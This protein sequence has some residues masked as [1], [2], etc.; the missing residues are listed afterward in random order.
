MHT[1]MNHNRMPRLLDLFCS[2]GGSCKGYQDAGFYVVGVD[3][4]YQPRYPGDY[5]IQ[6]DVMTWLPIAIETG[7]IDGFD[8]IHSSPPCQAHSIL[9]NMPNVDPESHDD[10]IEPVRNLL[11]ETGK[12]YVIENVPGAPLESPIRLCGSSFGL[13][14]QKHRLFELS[15]FVLAPPCQHHWQDSDPIYTVR[16]HGAHR[17]TGICYVFGNG[18][19]KGD[20]W[21]GAMGI[22]WMTRDE[23]SQAIPPAYTRWLG[24][25][26]LRAIQ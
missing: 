13:R 6:A 2:A 16:N 10:L 21:A 23:L 7:Y 18:T 4:V 24:E 8:V 9:G 25:Q 5:F 11:K 20:D 3:K 19:G 14:V 15:H 22:N 17:K 26:M 1:H 12:P